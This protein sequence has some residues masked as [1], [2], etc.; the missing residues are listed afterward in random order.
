M[1]KLIISLLLLFIVFNLNACGKEVDEYLVIDN[2]ILIKDVSVMDTS[3]SYNIYASF[4][5]E[6]EID[7][8][9][10]KIIYCDHDDL[11][12]C[13]EEK[14]S[15]TINL[16]K[17]KEEINY[18]FELIDDTKHTYRTISL[19]NIEITENVKHVIIQI[20]DRNGI[21]P[22]KFVADEYIDII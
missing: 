10:L 17:E 14:S 13:S 9:F 22:A 2:E 21:F 8:Y 15:M 3:I 5:E 19:V 4:L 16:N 12:V 11:L 6:N 7:D 1:K 20:Y 18:N